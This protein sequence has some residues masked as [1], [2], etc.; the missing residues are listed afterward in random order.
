M[1]EAR[2]RADMA[3]L[4]AFFDVN[5][6]LLKS[7]AE[8]LLREGFLEPDATAQMLSQVVFTSDVSPDVVEVAPADSRGLTV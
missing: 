5:R 1:L 2:R 7:T 4:V 8:R 6:Q 3:A